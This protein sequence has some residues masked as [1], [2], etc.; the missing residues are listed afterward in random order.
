MGWGHQVTLL[1]DQ[2]EDCC[3]YH[4]ITFPLKAMSQDHLFLSS[5]KTN[6]RRFI[7]NDCRS[8]YFFPRPF[9]PRP[10]LEEMFRVGQAGSQA[11][12]P[13]VRLGGGVAQTPGKFH[14]D[15]T[16]SSQLNSTSAE[17]PRPSRNTSKTLISQGRQA[18]IELHTRLQ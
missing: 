15:R 14:S 6:Q 2:A 17:R 18:G 12:G 11:P 10:T 5:R 16:H 8:N 3:A 7:V 1:Q 4:P 13:S 9:P